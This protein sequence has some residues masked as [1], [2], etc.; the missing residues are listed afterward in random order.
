MVTKRKNF[1]HVVL[2]KVK[3]VSLLEDFQTSNA[4]VV[5]NICK[6]SMKI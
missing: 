5:K 3:H 6:R 1:E 4:H 2:N